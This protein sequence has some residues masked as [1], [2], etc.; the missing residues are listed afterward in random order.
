AEHFEDTRPPPAEAASALEPKSPAAS[1]SEA[2]RT[3][4]S[5]YPGSTLAALELPDAHAPWFLVRV[6][7]VHDVRRMSG[8]TTIY[9]SSRSGRILANY[10]ARALPLKTRA[11]DAVYPFHTGEIGGLAGRCLVSLV[12][13][14][15]ITMISLGVSMWL[16]R[17]RGNSPARRPQDTRP[18]VYDKVR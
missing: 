14:W 8:R 17:R 4:L 2:L 11:W 6:T 12:A 16:V 18:A 5:L 10:D 13:L 9:V 3:A 15:L 1:V 7:Q